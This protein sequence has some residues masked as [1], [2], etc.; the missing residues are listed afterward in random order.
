MER[1]ALRV[2]RMLFYLERVKEQMKE[3][4]EDRLARKYFSI[5]RGEEPFDNLVTLREDIEKDMDSFCVVEIRKAVQ[6]CTEAKLF[7]SGRR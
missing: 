5:W 4:R 7:V 6:S 1:I 3:T 2:E